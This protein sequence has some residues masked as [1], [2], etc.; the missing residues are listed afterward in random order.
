MTG[1]FLVPAQWQA[2]VAEQRAHPRNLK[3]RVLSWGAAPASDTLLRSM[4]EAFPGT[5]ILAAFGQT[6]MSPVTCM[7]LGDDAIRK[8]GSVGKVIPTVSARV[9]DE[10]MNDVEVG[11]VGE[12]VYRAP[13]LMAGTGTTRRPPPKPSPG[14]VPFRRPRAPGRGGLHLGRGPQ[15]GHDHLRRREHLLRGGREVLPDIPRSPRWR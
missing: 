15:E 5:Q 9:V 7:L 10:N 2:V 13:T 8:L 14:L 12:I 6:E 11:Q 4:S 3:L 1:I